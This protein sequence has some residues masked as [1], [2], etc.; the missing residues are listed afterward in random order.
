MSIRLPS[1]ASTMPGGYLQSSAN[2][3]LEGTVLIADCTRKDGSVVESRI[4]LNDWVVNVNGA[5][6][7]QLRCDM[8]KYF[9]RV[10]WE[11]FILWCNSRRWGSGALSAGSRWRSCQ[12]G[13]W[14][15]CR[16][17]NFRFLT[18]QTCYECHRITVSTQN[19]THL[20]I[21]DPVDLSFFTDKTVFSVLFFFARRW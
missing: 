21:L 18:D 2:Q 9:L 4:D 6:G 11:I 5:L 13:W 1:E 12:S 15:R 7:W 3:R 16:R 17:V 19:K 14:T 20:I 8:Q 10:G